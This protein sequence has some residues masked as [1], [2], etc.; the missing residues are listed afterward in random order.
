MTSL[1]QS[2]ATP[3][4]ATTVY[5]PFSL[6]NT[7][8]ACELLRWVLSHRWVSMHDTRLGEEAVW[9]GVPIMFLNQ[10]HQVLISC[11]GNLHC[12]LATPAK[13]VVTNTAATLT[14]PDGTVLT[15]T[16]IRPVEA[17]DLSPQPRR[18]Q[19]PVVIGPGRSGTGGCQH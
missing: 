2:S 1:A 16:V 9:T 10:I 6:A 14:R 13:L 19:R 17:S 12:L 3:A 5:D 18:V 7:D 11:A 4:A 8:E 15:L